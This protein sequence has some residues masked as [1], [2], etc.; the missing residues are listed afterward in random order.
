VHELVRL[1]WEDLVAEACD[2]LLS[3][4]TPNAD[5]EAFDSRTEV[6]Q[7]VDWHSAT[8]CPAST[9]SRL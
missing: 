5:L 4:S 8:A 9:K 1:N 7:L 6:D 2:Y 3:N